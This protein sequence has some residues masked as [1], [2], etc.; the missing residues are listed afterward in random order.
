M[1]TTESRRLPRTLLLGAV[2]VEPRTTCVVLTR[3]HRLAR[4]RF[5]AV[6]RTAW[7]RWLFLRRKSQNRSHLG[8]SLLAI[9]QESL[10]MPPAVPMDR[11]PELCS[12][13][14]SSHRVDRTTLPRTPPHRLSRPPHFCGR[15]AS[16]RYG[17]HRR[18]A[19]VLLYPLQ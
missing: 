4:R 1:T 8:R 3:V 19:C 11:V 14:G 2:F 6:L 9:E 10:G 7:C 17:I 13:S 15:P 12:A 18:T 16:C 5:S